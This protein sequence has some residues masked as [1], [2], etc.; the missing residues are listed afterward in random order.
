MGG[1][2]SATTPGGI[3]GRQSSGGG[4]RG[5]DPLNVLILT[6]GPMTDWDVVRGLAGRVDATAICDADKSTRVMSGAIRCRAQNP[7]A[8]GPAYTVKC[9]DDFFAV[10]R[11]VET[12]SPGDVLVVD[13][14]G[15][16][17][18][19]AG[20]LFARAAQARGLAA[21]IVDGGYRDLGYVSSCSFP[22]FSR[23]VTPMAGSVTNLGELQVPIR[24]GGVSVSPGDVVVAD[25]EG[26]VVLDPAAALSILEAALNVKETEARAV[27]ALRRGQ[28]LSSC[29]NILEHEE[30]LGRGLPS[31]LR[32]TV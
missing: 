20:E 26:I 28:T 6:E 30:R 27:S 29:L 18:A 1:R 10:A 3:S 8:C 31:S 2:R 22:I 19:L 9:T 23:H 21:I 16:E 11:A 7:R 25:Q 17:I 5:T 15:T 14:G 4:A 12:A 13:G 24:C 32:F